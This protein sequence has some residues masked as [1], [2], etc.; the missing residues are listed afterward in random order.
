M[1]KLLGEV[2]GIAKDIGV[3]VNVHGKKLEEINRDMEDAKVNVSAGK[4]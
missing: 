1:H 4:E 2:H 3:E